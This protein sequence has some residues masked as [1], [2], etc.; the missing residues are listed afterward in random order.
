MAKHSKLYDKSPKL[1]RNEDGDVA[2]NKGGDKAAAG[3]DGSS[4]EDD[5]E[6]KNSPQEDERSS[7][8]KRHQEE[9]KGMHS[10]H[11]KDMKEMHSR[12]AGSDK[13][14]EDLIGKTENNSKE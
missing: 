14:G 5:G 7:M 8:H 11:E 10:R 9:Q 12:H 2:V 3:A 4:A 6:V 1:E 13:T